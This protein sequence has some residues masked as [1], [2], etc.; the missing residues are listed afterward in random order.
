M[1]FPLSLKSAGQSAGLLPGI[2]PTEALLAAGILSQHKFNLAGITQ[3]LF[4]SLQNII[5]A[6]QKAHSRIFNATRILSMLLELK[7]L[8]FDHVKEDI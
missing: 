7:I 8:L 6:I 5:F 4:L 2:K 1:F 3:I